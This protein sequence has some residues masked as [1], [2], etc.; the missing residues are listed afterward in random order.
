MNPN[1]THGRRTFLK[2]SAA[3]GAVALPGFGA[4]AAPGDAASYPERQIK[5]IDAMC[6][7]Y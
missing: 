6:G 5:I 7:E 1:D 4:Q 2:Q 3:L